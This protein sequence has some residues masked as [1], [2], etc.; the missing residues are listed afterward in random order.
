ML[1][2]K[3]KTGN[4]KLYKK[5]QELVDLEKKVIEDA[6]KE[7]NKIIQ[8]Y[9]GEKITIE[10]LESL[11]KQQLAYKEKVVCSD[12]FTSITRYHFSNTVF[13][14]KGDEFTSQKFKFLAAETALYNSQYCSLKDHLEDFIKKELAEIS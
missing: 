4:Q 14:F 8:K 2:Q 5:L 1:N 6:K 11:I 3:I 13:I 10:K 7:E 9:I 12:G